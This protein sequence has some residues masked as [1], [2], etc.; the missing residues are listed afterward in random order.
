MRIRIPDM[1]TKYCN[2]ILGEE[3]Y[4]HAIISDPTRHAN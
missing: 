4:Q 1:T 2:S 3:S